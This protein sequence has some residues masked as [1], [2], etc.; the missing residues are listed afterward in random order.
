MHLL[1]AKISEV[2]VVSAIFSVLGIIFLAVRQGKEPSDF[3]PKP[4][5]S[6]FFGFWIWCNGIYW[7]H[8]VEGKALEWTF[9]GGAFLFLILGGILPSYFA[10]ADEVSD[11][12]DREPTGFKSNLT[13]LHLR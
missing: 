4:L 10:K 2:A 1:I 11:T 3:G 9:R 8:H 7:S 5:I 6:L 13:A 12:L